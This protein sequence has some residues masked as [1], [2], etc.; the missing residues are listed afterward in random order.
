MTNSQLL[1]P[2]ANKSSVIWTLSITTL[3]KFSK[4]NSYVTT[5]HP[6]GNSSSETSLFARPKSGISD[7]VVVV[8]SVS[9][10][11]SPFPSGSGSEP[12]LLS[13]SIGSPEGSVPVPVAVLEIIV[14]TG[15]PQASTTKLMAPLSPISRMSVPVNRSMFGGI[16]V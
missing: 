3:P 14:P 4:L 12:L 8:G 13:S 11:S 5:L 10:S 9:S 1:K 6:L 2:E 15:Q 7:N 16:P